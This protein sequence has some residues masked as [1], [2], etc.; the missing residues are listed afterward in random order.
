MRRNLW[1]YI[2]AMFLTASAVIAT[3]T[4][5]RTLT[6]YALT[7]RVDPAAVFWDVQSAVRIAQ[8][9][10]WAQK[11][12]TPEE[13]YFIG[14]SVSASV[15]A[16]YYY[17][18]YNGEIFATGRLTPGMLYYIYEIGSVLDYAAQDTPVA[19]DG[20]YPIAGFHFVILDNAEINAF[21]APGGFVFVT[22]GFLALAS[23]ED[24]AA[25]ILAHEMGHVLLRHG[26]RMIKKSRQ[27]QFRKVVLQET[28]GAVS[29]VGL[30]LLQDVVSDIT[31]AV[32]LAGYARS[33]E[34]EADKFAYKLLYYSGYNPVALYKVIEKLHRLG[35]EHVASRQGWFSTHP[36][37]IDRMKKLWSYMSRAGR[38]KYRVPRI[39]F[40]RYRRHARPLYRQYRR[41][42]EYA[43]RYE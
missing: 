33:L 29:P 21:S 7:G 12:I 31:E 2:A 19:L 27:S 22:S 37:P 35:L 39:R 43:Y 40:L 26:V 8:T 11:S 6:T 15:M 4:G 5:C 38:P 23:S 34:Y 28:V 1:M 9:W 25:A 17:R 24:E 42:A 18:F 36:K 14:R 13:E 10:N 32:L 3:D 16:R 41:Y 20:F 30:A